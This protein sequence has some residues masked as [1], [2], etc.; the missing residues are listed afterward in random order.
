MEFAHDIP[1]A[2]AKVRYVFAHMLETRGHKDAARLECELIARIISLADPGGTESALNILAQFAR[3]EKKYADAAEYYERSLLVHLH[4]GSEYNQPTNNLVVPAALH[5]NR[6]MVFLNADKLDDANSEIQSCLNILPGDINLPIL[7]GPVLEKKGQKKEAADLF[8]RV[9]GVFEGL[10]K[11]YP[12]SSWAHNNVAW[13]AVRCRRNLDEALEHAQQAVA[14]DP[15]NARNLDTLAEV[16]FQKGDK[17]K[18]LELI[19]KCIKMDPKYVYF[20]NQLKRIE[21]GD[22]SVDVPN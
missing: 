12:K 16:Y 11:D 2:N 10:C 3:N 14:L 13:L 18:A 17:D 8:A 5:F 9:S 7:L 20:Q 19:K 21:A 6:A 22:P 1:L 4:A 15:E